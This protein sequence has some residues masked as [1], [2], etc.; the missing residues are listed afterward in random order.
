MPSLQYDKFHYKDTMAVGITALW[1]SVFMS[2]LSPEYDSVL[3]TCFG[4]DEP[5]LSKVY[6][7]YT[8]STVRPVRLNKN[9]I[10]CQL[11]LYPI[12]NI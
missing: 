12:D 1:K 3:V 2:T 6:H 4:H 7:K 11:G 10:I 5:K 9:A 8:K